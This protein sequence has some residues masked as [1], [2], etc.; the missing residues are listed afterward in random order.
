MIRVLIVDDHKLFRQGLS[1]LLYSAADI[2]IV[3]E[4]RDGLEAIALAHRLQPD[5]I[6]MD[7]EMPEMDGIEAT[8]QL[9]AEHTPSKILVL[10]MRTNAEHVQQ[11]AAS[12][13]HG[14]VVKNSE[15]RQ[16]ASAIRSVHAG[17]VACSPEIAQF[18]AQ[19]GSAA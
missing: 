16:L 14:Y 9:V 17:H 19:H 7:I 3:G 18:F 5:V 8:R 10:S 11:A 13:A 2:Q 12:G 1:A 4:A 6:L 15:R